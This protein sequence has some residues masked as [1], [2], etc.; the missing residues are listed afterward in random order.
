MPLNSEF[1]I[2]ATDYVEQ[3]EMIRAMTDALVVEWN[4]VSTPDVVAFM[5]NLATSASLQAYLAQHPITPENTLNVGNISISSVNC[6]G[7]QVETPIYVSGGSL[8]SKQPAFLD[9]TGSSDGYVVCN[10]GIPAV[11]PNTS[12]PT[13]KTSLPSNEILCIKNG[14][15]VAFPSCNDPE[16]AEL[17]MGVNNVPVGVSAS[18][19]S[20]IPPA[21]WL[22]ED[23]REV[24]KQTY[25]ALYAVYGDKGGT[26]SNPNNFKLLDKSGLFTV[27]YDPTDSDRVARSPGGATGTAQGS[28]SNYSTYVTMQH[29]HVSTSTYSF[30]NFAAM[31]VVYR[32]TAGV[33]ASAYKF[34][35]N[36]VLATVSSCMD[37]ST[38]NKVRLSSEFRPKNGAYVSIVRAV[39]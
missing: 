16:I 18:Y 14:E 20:K 32:I 25:A 38:S 19:P 5:N 37:E 9:I 34:I 29:T 28:V 23:G 21:G 24:S 7:L 3:L 39:I 17:F 36:S 33:G 10:G 30:P 35:Q 15:V 6:G 4:A 22:V 2:A 27:G 1:K 8:I 13:V 11:L 26:P 12:S 31:P